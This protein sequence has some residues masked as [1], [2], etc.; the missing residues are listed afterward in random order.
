MWWVPG[1]RLRGSEPDQM[2]A[3][4][5]AS[6]KNQ[7]AFLARVQE[8]VCQ[9]PLTGAANRRFFF[10]QAHLE[11]ARSKRHKLSLSVFMVDIDQLKGIND[12]YGH[13]A[14]DEA[15]KA[16]CRLR[17]R[18]CWAIPRCALPSAWVWRRGERWT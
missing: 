6:V 1:D 3:L 4:V 11:F 8:L 10:E 9:D 13:A 18:C 7:A 15:L 17:A 5:V 14:G 2:L 12:G 16:F